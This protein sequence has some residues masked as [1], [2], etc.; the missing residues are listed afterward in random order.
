LLCF[1]STPLNFALA[2]KYPADFGAPILER[3]FWNADFTLMKVLFDTLWKYADKW[4]NTG[5]AGCASRA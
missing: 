2:T 5:R 3:R 1:T 4:K